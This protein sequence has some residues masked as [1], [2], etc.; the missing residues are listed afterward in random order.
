MSSPLPDA[1]KL[2]WVDR[3]APRGLKPYLKLGRFDRPIGIWLLVLPCWC[4]MALGSIHVNGAWDPMMMLWF[5]VGAAA[6]RAAGCAYNDI[7]DREMD[8]Q[9]ARTMGRPIAAGTISLRQ[10]AMFLAWCLVVGLI[11]LLQLNKQAIFVSLLAIPL[12]GAYPY[13][14]RITWWPQAWLGLTFNWGALVGYVALTGMIS[15]DA[16][17]FYFAL[18]FWT[19]GY[20][21]IYACQDREDDAMIG[22]K[23]T[24]RLFGDNAPTG[25]LACYIMTT[26]LVVLSVAMAKPHWAF[27]PAIAVFALHLHRQVRAMKAE[28]ADAE[29]FLLI[30]KSNRNAG[31]LLLVCLWLGRAL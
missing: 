29:T 1:A 28:N 20:D 27:Y 30:F 14:K 19:L 18:A 17:L 8:A 16:V 3:F 12:V 10:G 4:G 7:I 5:L 9:V 23:S 21:T 31:L 24:A 6:M 2:N 11:V 15:A 26:L 22:V 25:V 13:M